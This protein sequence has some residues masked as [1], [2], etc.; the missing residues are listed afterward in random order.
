MPRSHGDSNHTVYGTGAYTGPILGGAAL[1]P[2][3][4]VFVQPLGA[5]SWQITSYPDE[6]PF[7][8]HGERGRPLRPTTPRVMRITEGIKKSEGAGRFPDAVSG[9]GHNHVEHEQ[10][11]ISQSRRACASS[12][13]GHDCVGGG[14]MRDDPQ[15]RASAL[16]KGSDDRAFCS[17]SHRSCCPACRPAVG[18][19]A[20]PR[21][22][23]FRAGR[24]PVDGDRDEDERHR[25]RMSGFPASGTA[26]VAERS[27]SQLSRLAAR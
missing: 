6:A 24:R 19:V 1:A 25:R 10:L 21:H 27:P 13:D 23:S 12:Q 11:P 16:S 8:A 2:T 7:A 17:C 9:N 26:Q 14:K 18:A 15:R 5:C 3:S 4:S 22:V 20:P